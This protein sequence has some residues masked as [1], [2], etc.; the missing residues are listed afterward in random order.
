MDD[1]M[2]IE[3]LHYE[4]NTSDS[5]SISSND[6]YDMAH[7]ICVAGIKKYQVGCLEEAMAL[8]RQA[9]EI[10][11]D[12]SPAIMNLGVAY[13]DYG[14]LDQAVTYFLR[15]LAI[16]PDF[17]D[18]NYNL[19]VT[20]HLQGDFDSAHTCYL[21]AIRLNPDFADAH[22]NLAVL[23]ENIGATCRLQGNLEQAKNYY[24]KALAIQPDSF[25]ANYNLAAICHLLRDLDTALVYYLQTI[26]IKPDFADA[27]TNLDVLL[28][29][30]CS[31]PNLALASFLRI[32]ENNP[33]SDAVGPRRIR[34]E[35]AS[36]CNLRCQHCPT[37]TNYRGTVRDIM[38]MA[39][40]DTVLCQMKEMPILRDVVFYLGGEPLLNKNL[41]L[42]CR[43]VK[44]ETNVAYTQFN[45]NGMLITE[46]ICQQLA[47]AKVD[48]IGVSI[49][50]ISPEENDEIRRGARY[51]TIVANVHLLV[52]YLPYTK[53]EI[54]NTIFKRPGEPDEPII[55]AFLVRDFP[56][57][58]IWTTYAMKWPGLDTEKSALVQPGF[59]S[60][61]QIDN[62]CKM[63][64]T[65]MTIRSNGDVVMCCYDLASEMVMGNIHRTGLLD[66]WS[67][68]TYKEIRKNMLSRNIQ[69]LPDVCKRCQNYSG[70]IPLV[71]KS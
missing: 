42:M 44:E 67:S 62:F 37:G 53:I 38:D 47:E 36:A 20:Y 13:K 65:E 21:Y 27:H 68:G 55:P 54:S 45:T 22:A 58:P 32:H 70:A 43:R 6:R 17:F 9:I 10:K 60:G 12:F 16:Q 39:M 1:Q 63:P 5:N 35:T 29:E 28:G 50:G 69:S 25:G 11:A 4:S 34:I 57:L 61:A 19:A 48:K 8:W 24:L 30:K 52:R 14:D 26:R 64:F 18:A 46:E 15:A 40:F 71:R 66:I 41:P 31:S 51:E 23:Y 49:D 3:N 56:G 33:L 7:E 2:S 59:D